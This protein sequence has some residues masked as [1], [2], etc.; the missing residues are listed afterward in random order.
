ML[1]D[2][3]GLFSLLHR[4]EPQNAKAIE[5][6]AQAAGRLTH[7]YVLAELIPLAQVRGLSG[8][9]TLDFSL[10]ALNDNEIEVVWVDDRL[11]RE[12]LTLLQARRD[13]G[14][15]L[16]DAVSFVLMRERGILEALT[17]DKHFQIVNVGAGMSLRLKKKRAASLSFRFAEKAKAGQGGCATFLLRAKAQA[18]AGYFAGVISTLRYETF[19]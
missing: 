16:C 19:V 4:D 11:H 18:N 10:R 2:T 1:P 13:K 14:Y 6:Y 15:S 8:S 9:V 3:S 17:T 5:L 7:G 12:A